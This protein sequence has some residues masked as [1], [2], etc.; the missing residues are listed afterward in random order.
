MI[1]MNKGD[2][3]CEKTSDMPDKPPCDCGNPEA[4][5]HGDPYGRREYCCDKCLEKRNSGAPN[6]WRGCGPDLRQENQP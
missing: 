4:S 2:Q 1:H 6:P 5:W 3:P